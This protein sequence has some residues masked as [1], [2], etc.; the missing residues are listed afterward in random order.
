MRYLPRE[1]KRE[2]ERANGSCLLGELSDN[3][4]R[5]HGNW[6]RLQASTKQ[7]ASAKEQKQQF[8]GAIGPTIAERLRIEYKRNSHHQQPNSA[9]IES[10]DAVISCGLRCLYAKVVN[11]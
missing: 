7:Q 10:D 5:N 11:I 6:L 3:V 1:R 4:A 2:T 9:A 8:S